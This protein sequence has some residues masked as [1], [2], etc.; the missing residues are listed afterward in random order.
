MV[1]VCLLA[2]LWGGVQK[3]MA[4]LAKAEVLLEAYL[5]ADKSNRLSGTGRVA[6]EILTDPQKFKEFQREQG[7]YAYMRI[8]YLCA[9]PTFQKQHMDKYADYNKYLYEASH[10]KPATI[11]S[12]DLGENLPLNVT[13]QIAQRPELNGKTADTK[14]ITQGNTESAK[15]RS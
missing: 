1:L 14:Q 11:I 15:E 7:Q 5:K 6:H 2:R 8:V 12:A 10:G 4:G 9:N 13:F 3:L